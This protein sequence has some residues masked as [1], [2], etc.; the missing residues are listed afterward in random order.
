MAIVPWTSLVLFLAPRKSLL[1]VDETSLSRCHK[2]A[3]FLPSLPDGATGRQTTLAATTPRDGDPKIPQTEYLPLQPTS[4]RHVL[5]SLFVTSTVVSIAPLSANADDTVKQDAVGTTIFDDPDFSCL[6]D[7]GSIPDDSVRIYLCRHGQTENN[8]LRLVQ[9]SRL[10]PP[11]NENGVEQAKRL[12]KA[13]ASASV[14]PTALW[15]SPLERAR[16]TAEIAAQQQ[17]TITTT[18]MATGILSS[19]REV[20]FGPTTEGTNVNQAQWQMKATYAQWAIGKLDTRMASDGES[21]REVRKRLFS[22]SLE[23]A[24][25]NKKYWGHERSLTPLCLFFCKKVLARVEQATEDLLQQAR[26]SP[27]RCIGIVSHSSFLRTLL[28]TLQNQSLAAVA[29]IKVK[30]A[31]VSVVDLKRDGS[32][33]QVGPKSILLGGWLSQAD[34]SFSLSYPT[35]TVLRVNENRHLGRLGV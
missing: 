35:S 16:Q 12:G 3:A 15:H 1:V 18:T 20:D 29:T 23:P 27:N 14:P 34:S 11:L 24:R 2:C 32:R 9:G 4:R 13:L 22:H 26:K 21:G 25:Q 10:N 8:R 30:N 28:A 6:S 17:S 19:I 31:S 5:E 33:V 7:L